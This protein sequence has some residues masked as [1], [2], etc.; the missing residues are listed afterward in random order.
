MAAA[1]TVAAAC[2]GEVHGLVGRVPDADVAFASTADHL[3]LLF[4]AQCPIIGLCASGILIRALA[5]LL[6]EK[7]AEPPVLAVAED[8]SAV[9]PLLGGHRGANRLAL[10]IAA[11]TGATAAVTTA[12]DVRFGV[13]FDDPPPDY[14]LANPE[15]VKAFVAALLADGG[16]VRLVGS[17]PWLAACQLTFASSSSISIT[18]TERAVVGTTAHL[19]Y[20]PRVLALGV[21]CERGASAA[22]M[23]AVVERTLGEA[24]LSPHAVAGVFSLDIKADELAVHELA[25]HLDVPARFF[26]AEELRAETPRLATPS[27]AVLREVGVA[28]VAEAAALAA[29]GPDAH[30]IVVKRKGTRTTCAI[31]QTADPFD[32]LSVGRPRGELAIVGLGPG[33]APTRTPAASVAL[34]AADDIVGY[35]GYLA[36]IP[37]L[38]KAT[39]LHGYSIGEEEQRVRAAL[40]LASSGR[41]VALV[42]SGDPGIYAMA[43]LVFE[44]LDRTGNA[45]WRRLTLS[46]VPGVS[47]LQAAAAKA[48]APLGHDFAAISLSDLLTPWAVIEARIVAAGQADFAIAFFNP[49]SVRRTTQLE[50][51][52]EILL[53]TRAPETPVM[54]A[55]N[56]GRPNEAFDV[57]TLE[58]LT[59]QMADMTTTVIVGARSSR[60]IEIAGRTFVYTPRGYAVSTAPEDAA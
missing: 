56:L 4:N 24:G 60:R 44:L 40:E 52:R 32:P 36:L 22:E 9:V 55:K 31:A 19:V 7:T 25:A 53:R 28:G 3:A 50:R 51:A 20:H 18:V 12:S 8:L 6:T 29:A 34:A 1:R 58:S 27:V 42:C 17:A 39:R 21:G 14:R 54:I 45:A 47:A 48:G 13:A 30:L 11:A 43:S 35:R 59:P 46:V 37:H 15:D 41:R 38:G 2:D 26:S 23:I 57:A 49:V 33:D 5:P 16:S 10:A